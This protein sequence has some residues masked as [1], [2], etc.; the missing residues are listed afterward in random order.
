MSSTFVLENTNTLPPQLRSRQSR[1]RPP[2]CARRIQ[3]QLWNYRDFSIVTTVASRHA[4]CMKQVT[5]LVFSMFVVPPRRKAA[6]PIGGGA[7]E[8]ALPLAN[9]VFVLPVGRKT[10]GAVAGRTAAHAPVRPIVRMFVAL[11]IVTRPKTRRPAIRTRGPRRSGEQQ[12]KYRQKDHQTKGFH[13]P[14]L[15]RKQTRPVKGIPVLKTRN[16]PP[17]PCPMSPIRPMR[18]IPPPPQKKRPREAAW[19]RLFYLT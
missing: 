2:E 12:R 11:G 14:I 18:P 17:P 15:F 13:V 19:K 7:A 4:T 16:V 3:M 8:A 9:A 6:R 10:A 5:G 1:I